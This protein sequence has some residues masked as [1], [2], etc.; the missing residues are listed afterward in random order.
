[1]LDL[2]KG[3][4]A[5]SETFSVRASERSGMVPSHLK[6]RPGERLGGTYLA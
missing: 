5:A 4:R 1:M 6:N 2:G 3:D